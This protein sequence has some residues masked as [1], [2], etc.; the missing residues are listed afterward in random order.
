MSKLIKENHPH[1]I[2]NALQELVNDLNRRNAADGSSKLD[3][4][5]TGFT[6]LD[7]FISGTRRGSLIVVASRP[8]MGKTTFA[9]NIASH[10][11]L[12]TKAPVLIFSMELSEIAIASKLV[13]QVGKVATHKLRTG[14]LDEIDRQHLDAAIENLRDAPIFV[15]ETAC[16]TA[17]KVIARTRD[18]I[19]RQGRLGLIVIDH[20]QSMAPISSGDS[21]AGEYE[22]VLSSIK[23]LAREIDTPIILISR[24]NRDLELRREKRPR[25]SDL[26]M[27]E[28][29]QYSDL[30][31]FLYRDEYY[32][33]DSAYKGIVEVIIGRHRYGSEGMIL[34]G[35]A[36]LEFSKFSSYDVAIEGMIE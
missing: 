16:L 31:M 27:C 13:S 20:L 15:D 14:N 22:E 21:T 8:A 33:P 17:E 11:A 1:Q 35:A 26:P 5:E 6:D 4:F 29:G 23:T 32:D 10:V 34:L 24:L 7:Q 12:N 30:L 25:I 36:Q 19:V 28:I 3:Q 9:L 18:I 2:N